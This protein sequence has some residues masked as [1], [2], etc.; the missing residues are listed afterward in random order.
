MFET[1]TL[2]PSYEKY[3]TYTILANQTIVLYNLGMT[4]NIKL[5]TSKVLP[6]LKEAGVTRS[7][8]FGSYVRGDY[9]KDSD[10]DILVELPKGNSLLDLVRLEKKLEKALG[11]KVDLLTYNSV[12]P[13][14]KSYIKK[15]QFQIL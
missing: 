8:L 5:I 1:Y 12:H 11:K 4:T 13:L 9:R 14:L 7:S 10:V 3:M 2:R 15:D 6:V